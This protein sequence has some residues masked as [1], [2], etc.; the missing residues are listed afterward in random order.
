MRAWAEEW[1][2]DD[3]ERSR[4]TSALRLCQEADDAI[5][6]S[7]WQPAHEALARAWTEIEKTRDY[8]TKLCVQRTAARLWMAQDRY[9]DAL[10]QLH[11]ALEIAWSAGDSKRTFETLTAISDCV[12]S[13]GDELMA[14]GVARAAAEESEMDACGVLEDAAE[15]ARE[16]E[17]SL[18]AIGL[19]TIRGILVAQMSY[20][21]ERARNEELLADVLEEIGESK[22]AAQRRKLARDILEGGEDG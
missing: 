16:A 6:A 3:E 18:Q 21:E 7:Q 12:R 20:P 14:E 2:L 15:S 19:L 9:P 11:N 17:E 5:A 1:E 4:R 13:A 8:E 22:L 10:D